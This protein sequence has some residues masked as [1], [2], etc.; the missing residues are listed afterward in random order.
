MQSMTEPNQNENPPVDNK[1][2]S[3][4][5]SSFKK[6]DFGTNIEDIAYGCG[7]TWPVDEEAVA[8]IDTLVVDYIKNITWQ[9][10]DVAEIRKKFDTECFLFLIRKEKE[11]YN[12]V[13]TLLKANHEIKIVNTI[14]ECDMNNLDD[15]M[16]LNDFKDSDS[17]LP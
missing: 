10:L 1:A 17:I 16:R 15:I 9:A 3:S 12:R 14:A 8:L 6:I 5:S 13:M 2:S 7:N 4:S 11:K